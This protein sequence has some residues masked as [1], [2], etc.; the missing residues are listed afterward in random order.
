M[1]EL[2]V[3]HKIMILPEFQQKIQNI[4]ELTIISI[5]NGKTS[6]FPLSQNQYFK[7]LKILKILP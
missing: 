4:S 7:H 2:Y 1:W 5:F 3:C 6:K